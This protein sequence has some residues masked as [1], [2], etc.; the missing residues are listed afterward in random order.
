MS[1]YFLREERRNHHCLRSILNRVAI[2][3][4]N[5]NSCIATIYP[6]HNLYF[7]STK[8]KPSKKFIARFR[9]QTFVPAWLNYLSKNGRSLF[10]VGFTENSEG[11]HCITRK[12]S[13]FYFLSSLNFSKFSLYVYNKIKTSIN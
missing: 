6:H 9:A 8:E 7:L 12:V 5:Y 13:A 10:F 4:I 1:I 11:N 3:I 2:Y